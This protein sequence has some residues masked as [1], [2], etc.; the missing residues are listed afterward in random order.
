MDPGR[1]EV[2]CHADLDEL[3]RAEWCTLV[4]GSDEA[5]VFVDYGWIRAW[6]ESFREPGDE[7]RIFVTRRSGALAGVA[8]FFRRATQGPLGLRATLRPVGQEHADYLTFPVAHDTPGVL[9]ALG[10]AL[11]AGD[12]DTERVVI[13]EV[14]ATSQLGRWLLGLSRAPYDKVV[15]LGE[16]PCPRIMLYEDHAAVR[17]L[18]HG[19]DLRRKRRKLQ[20]LGTLT[21]R[22]LTS[23]ADIEPHLEAFFD[24]HIRRWAT[25]PYPS[26]FLK[27]RNRDFYCRLVRQLAPEGK[28]LFS[29]LFVSDRAVAYHFGL[30]SGRDFLWYKPA[31]DVRLSGYSPGLVLLSELFSYALEHGFRYFDF[32]RGAEPFKMRFADEVA[33][34]RSFVWYRRRLTAILLRTRIALKSL[35]NRLV[36]RERGDE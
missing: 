4:A 16:T 31:F 19:S 29:I 6:W 8:P 25:T 10:N 35:L 27:Q 17:K 36:R 30:I 23:R 24:Q 32:T 13:P 20:P 12:Y 11:L 14:P 33:F 7:L 18:L 26:L 21:I 3:S 5:S 28:L 22:H 9:E 2:T 34:N 15:A 1:L